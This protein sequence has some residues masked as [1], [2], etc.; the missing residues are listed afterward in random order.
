MYKSVQI[1]TLYV[2]MFTIKVTD[3][4]LQI[5]INASVTVKVEP[6]HQAYFENTP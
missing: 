4:V 1:C 6:V 5:Y 3:I 2:Q